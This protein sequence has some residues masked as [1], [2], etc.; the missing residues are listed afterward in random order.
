MTLEM[1]AAAFGAPA[2]GAITVPLGDSTLCILHYGSPPKA[3]VIELRR[4]VVM[5]A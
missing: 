5:R 4:G 1:F 3:S 2:N